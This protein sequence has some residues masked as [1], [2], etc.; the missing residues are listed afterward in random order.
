MTA[1]DA[2][3]DRTTNLVLAAKDGDAPSEE[4]FAV[5]YEELRRLAG[6]QLEREQTGHTLRATALV[7]EAYLRLVDDTRVTHKGR[8]YFFGAVARAMRRVLVDHAR[9][10]QA[11]KRG[12]GEARI[13]LDEG[14]IA[15]DA[16]AD[17]LIDLDRALEELASLN[18]R[19]ARVV[20]CRFFAGL[21]V[22]ETAAVLEVSERTVKSDWAF[23]RAWLHRALHGADTDP[24]G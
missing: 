4:L 8:A 12:G 24:P 22:E 5:V 13:T 10:R 11:G 15:V 21:D 16:F 14:A 23:A 17:E 9:R 19:H 18:P 1:D 20:E 7:H 6:R 3:R 2:V